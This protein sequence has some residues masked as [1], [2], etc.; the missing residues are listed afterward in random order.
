MHIPPLFLHLYNFL[1]LPE[2]RIHVECHDVKNNCPFEEE[3]VKITE[4]I[5]SS[6]SNARGITQ[7]IY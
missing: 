5:S 4:G 1:N 6:L 2:T 7:I 3:S